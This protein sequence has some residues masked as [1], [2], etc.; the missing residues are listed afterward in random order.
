[1][2]YVAGLF[3]LSAEEQRVLHFFL[4]RREPAFVKILDSLLSVSPALTGVVVGSML[5]IPSYD[6]T[7]YLRAEAPLVATGLL[8]VDQHTLEVSPPSAHL[9]AAFIA[10]TDG[11]DA[12]IAQFV[13][14]LK[15]ATANQTLARFDTRDESI[16]TQ[17]LKAEVPAS[18]VHVLVHGPAVIDKHDLLA[19]LFVDI[20]VQGYAVRTKHVPSSDVAVWVSIAQ[21]HLR[22]N[23]P[24]AVL[25]VDGAQ[26]ALS[27]RASSFMTLLGLV[28][29]EE[30]SDELLSDTSLT[31][32]PIRC[33]WLSSKPDAM[34]EATLGRFLFTCEAR[35][36]SRADR[37]E[38]V[39][40]LVAASNLGPDLEVALAK[41][42]MISE[43]PI[44][45]AVRLAELIHAPG[46]DA[47]TATI[48]RAVAASQHVL[49]RAGTEDLRDS[50]THYDLDLLNLAGRFTPQQI[51]AALTRS[52]RGTLLFH[53]IPGAGK[54][55]FAEYLAVELDRPLMLRRA[56]DL[57]SKWVGESEQNIAAM[58]TAAEA[59]GAIL[60]VDEADSFL[61]DRS[62]ARAEWSVTQVNEFL[63]HL[64]RA[65][66]VVVCATNLMGDIDAAAMRRFTFKLEFLPLLPAQAWRMFCTESGFDEA[67]DPD[68]T[69]DTRR[70]LEAIKDLAPGDFATV[71]RMATILIGDEPLTPEGWLEQLDAEAKAKMH[72]LRRNAFGF[73]K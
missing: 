23:D 25:V 34:T 37:R 7:A 47:R 68:Q 29:D 61:R 62:L 36:G 70:R 16:I 33:V 19:R 54:T 8:R 13:T 56:S 14:P 6:V 42:Q 17:V 73:S 50:V 2:G 43:A 48:E 72:G 11:Y 35:A 44:A 55:Q 38:R 21:R 28:T 27:G 4:I 26:N 57:L 49:G 30:E 15:P 41:Y 5:R 66:G 63:Q 40:A 32:T 22:K 9:R 45:Q 52:G 69:A 12:F 64:E 10:T 31:T 51:V 46:D 39:A 24:T 1:M 58:F 18:G 20:G 60:F 71:K 67:A 59:E 3:G 65:R 53:G